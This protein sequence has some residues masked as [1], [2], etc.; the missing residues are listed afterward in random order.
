MWLMDEAEKAGEKITAYGMA[1]R[2]YFLTF[3][4][5]GIAMVRLPILNQSH[6]LLISDIDIDAILCSVRSNYTI[7]IYPAV[8]RRS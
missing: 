7:R 2:L 4:S 3:A 6:L 1:T 5:D 8:A